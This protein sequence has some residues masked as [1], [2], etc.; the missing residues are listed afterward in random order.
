[1]TS[2]PTPRATTPTKHDGDRG[3]ITIA[4]AFAVG[5]VLVITV[6][7]ANVLVYQ[8]GRGVVRAALDEGVRVGSRA[9]EGTGADVCEQI[10]RETLDQLAAGLGQGVTI[11]CADTGDSIIATAQVHFDGWL[12]SVADYDATFTASAAREDR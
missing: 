3:A 4:T 6:M 7:V 10:A 1:M 5:V 12:T 9:T 8:Y 2:P 11:Q